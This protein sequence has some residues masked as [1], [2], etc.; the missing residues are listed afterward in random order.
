LQLP[1][2]ASIAALD[3]SFLALT[4]GATNSDGSR[5]TG[6]S[7]FGLNP[8]LAAM[9]SGCLATG[10]GATVMV[11]A[12]VQVENRGSTAGNFSIEFGATI[13]SPIAKDPLWF[14]A[15]GNDV[16]VAAPAR[17]AGASTSAAATVL[18][19]S[20]G[21]NG[22]QIS[23]AGLPAGERLTLL[24]NFMVAMRLPGNARVVT[25]TVVN[26]GD[27]NSAN[28]TA[29]LLVSA[30]YQPGNA[31]PPA[32]KPVAPQVFQNPGAIAIVQQRPTATPTRTPA[33]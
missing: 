17:V 19:V 30:G 6:K 21:S 24:V 13:G 28:N 2:C 29:S 23:V 15:G 3:A 4:S 20:P 27:S 16:A 10:C 12:V 9:L 32:A 7:C 22:R 18:G 26:P 8:S 5:I 11:P 14:M 33:R 1:N 25:A 31:A